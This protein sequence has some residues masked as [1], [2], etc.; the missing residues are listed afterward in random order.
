MILE[1]LVLHNYGLYRGR[2]II[3]LAPASPAKPVVLLGGLNGGGKTTILDA[4]QLALYGRRAR[5][6]NRG[7][8]SYE[9]YLTRCINKG[10]PP[11]EGAAVEL[12]FR[13]RS[14]GVE[15]TYRIHRSWVPGGG[16]IKER[17]QVM[18]D[19]A[20]D[21]VLTDEW[22]E[23]VEEFI[24][25]SMAHLFFFDGEKIEA[26]AD[27]ENSRQ[28]LSK[29]VSS[30]LGLDLVERLRADLLVL[31]SRQQSKLRTEEERLRLEEA[32][33]ELVRLEA[34]IS[35]Y[36]GKRGTA[37]NELDQVEK[38][39]AAARTYYAKEGG[40]LFDARAELE[41][42]R[43]QIEGRLAEVMRQLGEIATG[44]A[45]L[46][47]VEDLVTAASSR[48]EIEEDARQAH[49]IEEIL[50]ERDF[51]MLEAV[52]GL[53]APNKVVSALE[54]FITSDRTARSDAI[55]V[56]PYLNLGPEGVSE[57]RIFARGGVLGETAR[58]LSELLQTAAKVQSQLDDADRRLAGVPAAESLAAVIAEVNSLEVLLQQHKLKLEALDNEIARLKRERDKKKATWL[59]EA[60]RAIELGLKNQDGAR[61][62]E[63]IK[64]VRETL[65]NFKQS[66]VRRHVG[67]IEKLVLDS[68]RQLLRK[69]SLISELRIDPERFSLELRGTDGTVVLPDRLSAGERQ[70]LAVSILW[71]LARAS[72][73][74]L[75]A[76]IDTPLG[77][78]DASHRLNLI[79]RYFPNASHQ[80]LLL[81]TDEEIDEVLYRKLK[82]W[83]GRSY[84]LDF[85]DLRGATDV[86]PGYFW[87]AT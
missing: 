21:R 22:N 7:G 53:R 34:T 60:E 47:L 4:I 40:H 13:Q 30:L 5:C 46:L 63:H 31:A 38:R 78:L 3:I 48:A 71:G 9:E 44:V 51:K 29:A 80:V 33:S 83:I 39:L 19:G 66:V 61:I 26:F 49:A 35:D 56:E 20:F 59:R 32:E 27:L 81:S 36:A 50:V 43:R 8:L 82:P 14:E 75:P 65:D 70:L 12:Q 16:S 55:A 77:R 72:G 17:V 58:G 37:Q 73:R 6:S 84:T 28:L 45:P 2:H 69:S 52:R 74:P 85:D 41:A 79:E 54:E 24:P 67:Q 76:V 10:V 64:R 1:E 57:L 15:H 86:R 68:F 11:T 62:V 87:E 25:A 18:K 23:V 42:D